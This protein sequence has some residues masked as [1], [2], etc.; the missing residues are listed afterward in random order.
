M[1]L[2]TSG[3]QRRE[4]GL[5]GGLRRGESTPP[6]NSQTGTTAQLLSRY[7]HVGEGREY[8]THPKYECA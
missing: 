3:N 8:H 6:E 4:R 7:V 2:G 1:G 5:V